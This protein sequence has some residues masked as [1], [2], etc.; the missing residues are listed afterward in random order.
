MLTWRSTQRHNR[1]C[2]AITTA[3]LRNWLLTS[4]E[5]SST[6]KWAEPLENGFVTES[7]RREDAESLHAHRWGRGAPGWFDRARG[8]LGD[9]HDG[10]QPV[11][12]LVRHAAGDQLP[13]RHRQQLAD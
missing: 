10:R 11:R 13:C 9:Q 5:A 4:K 12:L 6:L 3:D 1:I 7:E 8:Q 2:R